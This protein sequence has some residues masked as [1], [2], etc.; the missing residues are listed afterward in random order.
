MTGM[1]AETQRVLRAGGWSPGRRISIAAWRESFASTGLTMHD[2]AAAFLSE[3]G[4]LIFDLTV[5]ATGAAG[6]RVLRSFEVDPMVAW[7]HAERRF[8]KYGKRLRRALFP[9]GELNYGPALLGMDELTEV[10]LIDCGI[11]CFGPLPGALDNLVAD[12]LPR[13]TA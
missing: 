2:A 3:F 8:V 1:S 5:A 6:D 7:G 12:V 11:S 10:W 4:G 13:P 9:L